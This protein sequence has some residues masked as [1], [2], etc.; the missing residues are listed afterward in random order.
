MN[1]EEKVE[2]AKGVIQNLLD[3]LKFVDASDPVHILE[4][5]IE[6]VTKFLNG[7]LKKLNEA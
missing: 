1:A 4:Y 6:T 5:K 3:N 2:L 7:L